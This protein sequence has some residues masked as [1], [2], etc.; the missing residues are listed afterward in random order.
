VLVANK[1]I[2]L[3]FRGG[4]DGSDS[5]IFANRSFCICN[6]YKIMQHEVGANS[7]VASDRGRLYKINYNELGLQYTHSKLIQVCRKQLTVIL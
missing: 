5:F 3:I 7:R 4:S 1:L 6:L 2:R